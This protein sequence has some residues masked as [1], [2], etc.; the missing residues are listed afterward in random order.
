M[1]TFILVKYAINFNMQDLPDYLLDRHLNIL[2][3]SEYIPSFHFLY[4][5]LRFCLKQ[6]YQRFNQQKYH[7]KM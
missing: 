4:N 7:K 5:P 2:C 6:F 3:F 1:S